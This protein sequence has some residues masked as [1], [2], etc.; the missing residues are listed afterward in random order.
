VDDEIFDHA[1]TLIA[2]GEVLP[3]WPVGDAAVAEHAWRHFA[4]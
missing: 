3:G 4:S 2:D 1:G